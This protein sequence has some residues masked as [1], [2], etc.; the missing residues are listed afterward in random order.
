MSPEFLK[1]LAI[2]DAKGRLARFGPNEPAAVNHGSADGRAK[3]AGINSD[4]RCGSV[5][6]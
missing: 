3:S 2:Q 6:K 4:S 5:A 1:G